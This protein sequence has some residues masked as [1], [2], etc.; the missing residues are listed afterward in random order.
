MVR[1]TKSADKSLKRLPRDISEKVRGAIRALAVAPTSGK[2][3]TG[4][5]EGR[6]TYRVGR[7]YR[8]IYELVGGGDLVVRSIGHRRDV[9]R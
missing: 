3:L 4:N 1:L 8:I 2:K 6:W 9:Y 5:L 7:S